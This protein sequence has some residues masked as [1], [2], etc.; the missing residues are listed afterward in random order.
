MREAQIIRF[1][2]LL[3]EIT[4]RFPLRPLG[5]LLNLGS[6]IPTKGVY[7]FFERGENS[8][9][10]DLG[11]VVRIGTHG[12]QAGSKATIKQRLS[13]HKGPENGLGRHRASVY[14]ELIGYAMINQHN[15][16]FN[17]WGDR[18]QKSNRQVIEFERELEKQV[19]NYIRSLSFTILEIN[20]ESS[21]DNDRAFVEKNSIALLS[22]YNR[23]IID[24]ASENW[25][26][27]YTKREKIIQSGLWNSNYV[28]R[29]HIDDGFFETMSVHINN[30]KNWH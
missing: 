29:L 2:S 26:G 19:S 4:D 10:S 21:K 11:R 30:M 20:G 8:Q 18:R 3:N 27:G 12:V 22:N 6:N 25:L 13:N 5:D 16:V 28:E 24:P 14:R 7:F 23:N 17:D 1:Y 15:L 9:F